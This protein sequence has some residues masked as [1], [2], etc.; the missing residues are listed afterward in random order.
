MNTDGGVCRA[1]AAGD[2][3]DSRSSRDLAV[4]VRHHGGAAFLTTNYGAN[5][6]LSVQA[7]ERSEVTFARYAKCHVAAFF[8]QLID[9]Y[10]SAMA[11]G[12]SV[13]RG[14]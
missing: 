9:Q 1:G 12:L 2:K 7:I 14:I 5:V 6:V 4:G 11:H 3:C 10:L 8:T 13:S